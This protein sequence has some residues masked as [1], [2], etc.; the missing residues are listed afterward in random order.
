[1][2]EVIPS[3]CLERVAYRGKLW[4]AFKRGNLL[5]VVRVEKSL[6]HSTVTRTARA[7]N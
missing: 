2:T 5:Q 7:P 4:L 1:M 3:E 6:D